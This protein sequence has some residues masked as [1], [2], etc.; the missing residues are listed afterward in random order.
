LA[1]ELIVQCI[2]DLVEIIDQQLD[3]GGD[4]FTGTFLLMKFESFGEQLFEIL[5]RP[6][7]LQIVGH[8][9][10]SFVAVLIA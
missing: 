5:C 3:S 10:H 9:W 1:P 2:F 4:W 6:S 8:V 7:V